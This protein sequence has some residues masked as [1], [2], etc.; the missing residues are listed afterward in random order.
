MT[1]PIRNTDPF[2]V[3]ITD[4]RR[5]IANAR[6]ATRAFIAGAAPAFLCQARGRGPFLTPAAAKNPALEGAESAVESRFSRPPESAP[7]DLEKE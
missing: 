4:C 5:R 6:Q 7:G 2:S 3:M 1:E